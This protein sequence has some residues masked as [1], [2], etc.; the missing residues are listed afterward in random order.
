MTPLQNAL[1]PGTSRAEV[2]QYL[3]AKGVRYQ[4]EYDGNNKPTYEIEV[5]EEPGDAV[6]QHWTVYL[7]MPFN[8][9]DQLEDIH[10]RKVGD[11][12]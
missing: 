9:Q 6:C 11:C 12:L 7:A 3:H 2:E 10:V 1:P 4:V 5:G 8:K